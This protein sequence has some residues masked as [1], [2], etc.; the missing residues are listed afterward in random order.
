MNRIAELLNE[1]AEARKFSEYCNAARREMVDNVK[2]SDEYKAADDVA[3]TA[4]AT[5]AK[6]EEEIKLVSKSAFEADGNK[7]PHPKIEIKSFKTYSINDASKVL[8]WVKVNLADALTYDA[9]KVKNYATK[10]GSVDGAEVGE[11]I[12]VQIALNLE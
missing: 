8:A 9:A 2:Q 12:R 1:L 5:I 4:E 10:I 11:E 3:K 7:H 6:L